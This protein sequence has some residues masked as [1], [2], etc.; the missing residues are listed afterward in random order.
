M[1][2]LSLIEQQ[3]P[4]PSRRASVMGRNMVATSQPLAVQAGIRAL[5]SGGNAVDAAL[6]SAITL[7]VVEPTMNG[8]GS[9]AF[10]ILW[11]G[12]SLH[13][14]N[15]SGRS[16]KAM[17]IN[18]FQD[19]PSMPERGWDTVTVPGAVS[20]W[21]ALSERF[22]KLPFERLFEDAVR[23]A[24]EGFQVTPITARLW[25]EAKSIFRGF[26]DFGVFLPNGSVPETGELFRFP[27]QARTLEKIA[28][29]RGESFYQ[30]KLAECM[31]RASQR[32]GGKMTMADLEEHECDWVEPISR[33]Y[34]GYTLHEI[35]PNGQGLGALIMLGIL[36]HTRIDEYEPDSVDAL[37]CQIECMKLAFAD[38][39]RYVSDPA[40]SDMDVHR[41]LDSRYLADRARQVDMSR[42]AEPNPGMPP[43]SGTVYLTSA[44]ASGMMV[45]FIQSNYAGFGSG[46][47]IPGT[48][49]SLQ[50]RGSAFNLQ[51]GHPNCLA[52]GKRPFHTIIPAFLSQD[53]KPVMSFGVMGAHMQAQ[54]HAQMLIRV[55]DQGLSPQAAIDAPRWQVCK[56]N[57]ILL[58]S[59]YGD[60]VR[61][62]L[63]ARS[64]VVHD[65]E[66][67]QIFE[68]G[69]AQM[70]LKTE[71]GYVGGS[72]PRKDGMVS[73][74]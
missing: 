2:Q 25:E 1:S 72:D 22:G 68:M 61:E 12:K 53:G 3:F 8:I 30:G 64:H 33:D 11:D 4:F 39:F 70:I 43:G 14:L 71:A 67:E 74:Y 59:G 10:C 6:A 23:Y 51:E 17:R 16:F 56:D 20:A 73:A 35:P 69:G 47:V 36:E 63:R 13:G 15:A 18:D 29:T 52:G 46:I 42:S 40:C 60:E 66:F 32:D 28:S 65:F 9:D 37:H 24:D 38:T 49:I 50:N 57:S 55:L 41:L 54:G 48:G 34:H 62:G 5:Q 31:V 26:K 7:T 44:D 21:V 27:D 45:S 19:R 58:E